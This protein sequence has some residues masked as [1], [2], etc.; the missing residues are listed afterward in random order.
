MEKAKVLIVEDESIIALEIKNALEKLGHSITNIVDTGVKAIEKAKLNQPD[1]ILMDIRLKGDM[2]GIKTAEEIRSNLDIPIVFLTAHAE[3]SILE[4]AKMI[5]P[6]GYLLKPV[7]EQDLNITIKIALHTA[8]VEA[9]RKKAV[10]D[11]RKMQ[12]ELEKKVEERTIELQK[13]KEEAERANQAKS[14]FLNK[15]SHELRSPL[16]HIL[17]F[18][19]FGISR[20]GKIAKDDIIDY[21]K[22][23]WESGNGLLN[24]LND[25]LD[26]S[27]LES[28][29]MEYKMSV[30]N[31]ETIIKRVA[32]ESSSTLKEK[33]IFLEIIKP[34]EATKLICDAF[35][36]G[37]VVRN[38]LANAIKYSPQGKK[39]TISIGSD[40][41][42]VGRRVGDNGKTA[43]YRVTVLDQGIGI[44]ED[45][46]ESIFEKFIQ[47]SKSKEHIGG[48]GLGLTICREIVNA[49]KGKI[50]AENIPEGGAALCFVLPLKQEIVSFK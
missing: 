28:G 17:S 11:L 42:S 44:A 7:H 35:K 40:Q 30:A 36:I 18:A 39:I 43:G 3:E 27:K 47:S 45:E 48:T 9:E 50:W 31:L 46:L 8:K 41:L 29:K 6:F 14:D 49:H 10:E 12:R 5:M 2:N 15:T 13:A 4:R 23:I 38:L 19:K 25:L 22:T 21:F 37:Q 32:S 1:I 20:T 34:E 33:S 16:H 24:L 26:L